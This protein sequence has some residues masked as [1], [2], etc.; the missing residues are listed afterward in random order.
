[1]IDNALHTMLTE[2]IFISEYEIETITGHDWGDFEAV[3]DKIDKGVELDRNDYFLVRQALHVLLGFRIS[4]DILTERFGGNPG[5]AIEK[6]MKA[7]D[8]QLA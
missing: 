7:I 6:M 1:M 5:D 3:V 2:P 8:A 4:P